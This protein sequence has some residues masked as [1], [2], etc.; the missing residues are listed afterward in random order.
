MILV[1][2]DISDGSRRRKVINVLRR[3]G[4]RVQRSVFELWPS[5]REAEHLRTRL[6]EIIDPAQDSV[7]LY[8]L[9][10]GCTNA[11]TELGT[12]PAAEPPGVVIII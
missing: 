2:Y 8:R 5:P 3:S 7:R 9:C 11:V 4:R 12:G 6:G 10:D 1:T